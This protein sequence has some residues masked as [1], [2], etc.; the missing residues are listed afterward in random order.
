MCAACAAEYHDPANRRFHAQPVCCP[1]CGPR[2]TLLA[3][4]GTAAVRP[5]GPTG[6]RAGRGRGGAGRRPGTRG[7]GPRRLPPGGGRGQ[8]AGRGPAAGAQAPGRQAVRGDGRGP[9]RCAGPVRGGRPG[10]E[11]AG[12]SPAAHRAAAAPGRPPG[13]TG[14][15]SAPRLAAAVAPGNRQLGVLLP[16]TPLHHLLLRDFARPMVLTSGNVSDEPIAYR[17]EDALARLG[18]IADVFL[19]HDRPIHI[20]TDDSVVRP[21]RGREAVLRRSRGYVPEPLTV[22]SRFG[23]PVLACGA[24]LKN[25]FCLGREDRAFLSHHVGDLENYETLRSFTDGHRALPAAVRRDAADRG[26]RPAPG[27]PVHQVRPGAGRLR[28]GRRAAPSRAHRLLPGRQRRGRAGHRGGLR[29]HR[30]RAGRHDLG[31][32]IPARRPGRRGAGRAPGRPADAR[33]RGRDPPALADGRRLPGR[34]LPGRPA[35]GP[36]CGGA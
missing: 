14:A 15:A 21:F 19:T 12:Q 13:A 18:G 5:G 1:A 9:G 29:R 30:L 17:D 10:G 35:R 20:R 25:T 11:P 22:A 28:A 36:G 34:R 2:L 16:Y 4:D 31:R 27:L 32:R 8:R 33:R 3:A 24:E 23:R 26:A 6:R 7:E